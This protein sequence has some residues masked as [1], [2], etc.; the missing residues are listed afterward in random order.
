VQYYTD[1]PRLATIA[2]VD[3]HIGGAHRSVGV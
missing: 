1:S 2:A 3:E